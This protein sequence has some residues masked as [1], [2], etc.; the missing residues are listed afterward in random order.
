MPI[1]CWDSSAFVKLLVE[2]PGRDLAVELWNDSIDVAASRLVIPE[3]GAAFAAARRAGRLDD[4]AHRA[5]A[6]EW[7]RYRRAVDLVELAPEVAERASM[8]AARHALSGADAVHLASALLLVDADPI[9]VTWD[10]RLGDAASAA[11]LDVVP[12]G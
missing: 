5:A 3:V 7:D 2:E 4:A 8:L 1:A 12:A 6:R 9:F 11:G 10:R